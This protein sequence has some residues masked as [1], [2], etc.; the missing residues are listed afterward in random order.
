M[1]I[2]LSASN[3][4]ETLSSELMKVIF[5]SEE[6][7]LHTLK[8]ILMGLKVNVLLLGNLLA[9]VNL[10]DHIR[11]LLREGFVLVFLLIDGGLSRFCLLFIYGF[12]FF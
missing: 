8:I 7:A 1:E 5:E 4:V 3:C 10:F 11:K 6:V 2:F 12:Y 9:K